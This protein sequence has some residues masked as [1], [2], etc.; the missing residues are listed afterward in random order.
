MLSCF[1]VFRLILCRECFE[2][3]PVILVSGLARFVSCADE[4]PHL[5][6]RLRGSAHAS[7]VVDLAGEC[8]I[9]LSF[10]ELRSASDELSASWWPW[11]GKSRAW[12][13]AFFS[14][15]AKNVRA[16]QG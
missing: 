10:E 5:Q 14:Q 12:C 3:W 13:R 8:G 4:S 11:S 16:T 1:L 6:Q 7:Q 9:E 2:R 15:N